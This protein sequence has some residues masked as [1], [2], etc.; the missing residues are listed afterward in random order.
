[1]CNAV[2]LHQPTQPP[3][4]DGPT[5]IISQLLVEIR[6]YD[7][8]LAMTHGILQHFALIRI[9]EGHAGRSQPNGHSVR[10]PNIMARVMF[11][12]RLGAE[13]TRQIKDPIELQVKD[14]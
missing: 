8:S 12:M 4:Q 7:V 11:E 5:S 2:P 13:A 3:P 6:K 9:V 10:N 14:P 1:M